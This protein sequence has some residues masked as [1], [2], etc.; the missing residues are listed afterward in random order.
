M[1]KRVHFVVLRES[2]SIISGKIWFTKITIFE[3]F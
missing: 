1:T 3:K 2:V